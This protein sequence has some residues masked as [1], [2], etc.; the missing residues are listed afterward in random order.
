[1]KSQSGGKRQHHRGP[2]TTIAKKPHVRKVAFSRKA[3]SRRSPAESGL[4]ANGS[5]AELPLPAMV[6][7]SRLSATGPL[8]DRRL[9]E[10]G[11]ESRLSNARSSLTRSDARCRR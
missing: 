5:I 3:A 2:D 11:A 8:A 9:R 1:M 7:E 10:G 4:T 6:R